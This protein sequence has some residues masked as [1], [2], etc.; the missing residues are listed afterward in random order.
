MVVCG[1]DIV[2]ETTPSLAADLALLLQAAGKEA[3]LFY[4]LPGANAFGAGLIMAPDQ[5]NA[6][7]Q[8]EAWWPWGSAAPG[9]P[10]GPGQPALSADQILE[11]ID[12]GEIKALVLVENDPFWQSC[13][14]ERLAWA[15][16]RLELLVV[17]DY[18]PSPTAARA[19]VL[20][21]TLSLFERTPSSFVNQEGRAQVGAA[22]AFRRH[23]HCPHQPRRSI[24][25]GPSLIISP[26]AIPALRRRFCRS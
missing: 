24:R 2:R 6:A 23:A 16:E 26:G 11:A 5:T 13:D 21:P 20:L 18:L 17:L 8:P 3:G 14:E 7:G 1:T 19:H 22:G 12:Q 10:L 9:E 25:P 4:L 15:L